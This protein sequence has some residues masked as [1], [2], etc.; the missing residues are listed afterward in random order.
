MGVGRT[1]GGIEKGQT[2]CAGV[3]RTAGDIERAQTPTFV[4]FRFRQIEGDTSEKGQTAFGETETVTFEET[5]SSES[6]EAP[7]VFEQRYG[8]RTRTRTR[9]ETEKDSIEE[10]IR[11][12]THTEE[13]IAKETKGDG[14]WWICEAC[15]ESCS[16]MILNIY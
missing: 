8:T 11:T 14:D 2:G 7:L 4:P 5:G 16:C 15:C 13:G 10:G 12:R 1:A 6:V 9:A 3:G